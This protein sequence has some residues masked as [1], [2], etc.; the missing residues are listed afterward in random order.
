M[1]GTRER[2]VNTRGRPRLSSLR[3]N[4]FPRRALNRTR[5]WTVFERTYSEMADVFLLESRESFMFEIMHTYLLYIVQAMNEN[6][7]HE[8]RSA[9]LPLEMINALPEKTTV[10]DS[11][12]DCAICLEKYQKD[13]TL[14]ILLCDHFFHKQCIKPWLLKNDHCP[15][16]RQ[17]LI[18]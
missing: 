15:I 16:C 13:E 11:E 7:A 9:G 5:P 14:S 4:Y 8:N 2:M 12:E 6:S 17:M 18:F 10:V 1:N 3:R